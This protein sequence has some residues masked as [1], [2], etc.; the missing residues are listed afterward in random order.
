MVYDTVTKA[1]VKNRT[2]LTKLYLYYSF[3]FYYRIAVFFLTVD[4]NFYAKLIIINNTDNVL[5]SK[6]Y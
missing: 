3:H 4:K 2:K 5:S 6:L 1:S